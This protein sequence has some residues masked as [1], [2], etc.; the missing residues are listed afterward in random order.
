MELLISL[1]DITVIQCTKCWKF[2]KRGHQTCW[3]CLWH[4]SEHINWYKMLWLYQELRKL[5]RYALTHNQHIF[6]CIQT[7][8]KIIHV[9]VYRD[10]NKLTCFTHHSACKEKSKPNK[11]NSKGWM[12]HSV[13]SKLRLKCDIHCDCERLFK[14]LQ[15]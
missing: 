7:A 12:A 10:D 5:Y 1:S 8:T 3:R 15:C 9:Y 13:T 11:T 6:N 2:L 14:R 4:W